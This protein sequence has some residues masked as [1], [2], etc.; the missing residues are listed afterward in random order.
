MTHLRKTILE[1]LRLR[2]LTQR[3]AESYLRAVEEFSRFHHRPPDQSGPEEIRQYRAHLFT[4]RKLYANTV[5]Q[6]LSALRFFFMKTLKR[7]WTVEETPYPKRG[8]RLEPPG[9]L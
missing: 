1:E 5:C 2:N 9:P 8:I 7:R 3:T 6:Y 4:D